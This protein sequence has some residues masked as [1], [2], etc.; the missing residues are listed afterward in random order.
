MSYWNS[1]IKYI[2][3]YCYFFFYQVPYIKMLHLKQL[4]FKDNKEQV[5]HPFLCDQI[6]EFGFCKGP[7]LKRHELCKTLDKECL[8]IPAKCFVKIKL[9]TIVSASH[10]Y[11]RILKYSTVEDPIND[12]DWIHVYDS[13]EVIQNELKNISERENKIIHKSPIIGEMVMIE[14]KQKEFFRAVVLNII[15]GWLEIKLKVKL[16][17]L[18]L[19]EEIYSNKVFLLPNHLKQ[20][21]PVAVEI[22]ISSMEP[23]ED[24]GSSI[25]SWPIATTNVV[26]GLLELFILENVEFICKVELTLGIT[27]WVNWLLVIKCKKCSHFACK[28]NKDP[29]ELPKKLIEC[30]LAI[31]SSQLIN[32]IA[33][34]GKYACIWKEQLSIDK[35]LTEHERTNFMKFYEKTDKSLFSCEEQKTE[36]E[37]IKVQWAHLSED[38]IFNVSVSYIANPKCFLVQN[39]KFNERINDLQKDI[40]IAVNNKTVEQLTCATV[41]TVCLAISPDTKQY[42]RV[43]IQQIDKETAVVLYVDYGE[44][45]KV[46][47]KYL[48]T[49]PPSVIS[50]LPFQV[51]ECNLSGFNNILETD[52]VDQFIDRFLQLININMYLKVLS[53]SVDTILTGGNSYEVVLFNNEI[54]L[55]ITMANEFNMYV[56]NTQIQTILSSNYKDYEYENIDNKYENEDDEY[57]EAE[58]QAQFQLLESLMNKS[59]K[60]NE[61]QTV[62]NSTNLSQ[63]KIENSSTKTDEKQ[64]VLNTSSLSEDTILN[65]KQKKNVYVKKNVCLD[66]NV[67]PIIPQCY[68]H[69][70]ENWIFLKLN[71]LA[72]KKYNI[73]HTMDTITINVETNSVSYFFTA[74]LYVSITEELF[75]CC[76][77][78]DGIHINAQKLIQNENKWPRL[79]KCPKRHKYIIYDTEYIEECEDDSWIE[80]LNKYKLMS[81]HQPLNVTNYD[82][83]SDSD[84]NDGESIY[85]D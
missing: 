43:C 75:S 24:G 56:N 42:N 62:L 19:I 64:I 52:I 30:N 1:L 81:L 11:G 18:G 49:I 69:Q 70:N 23:V 46:K 31:T 83:T 10:F 20:F 71:I 58:V 12:R 48:L 84:S 77:S 61:E 2:C 59:T 67:I 13:F 32:K 25:L 36:I 3:D 29:L 15:N 55:N 28:L 54:N 76:V 72:V 74:V 14:T 39:L 35:S 47:I 21:R 16:I 60:T 40:N 57:D 5:V 8:N 68:W 6:K 73:S 26:R 79:L 63:D 34:L 41:G 51:I 85:E 45:Y 78:F 44:I 27:L 37:D 17:D 65:N 50:K 7:C 66:C 38:L 9:I 82:S 22:V 80:S 4:F 33:D 53:S